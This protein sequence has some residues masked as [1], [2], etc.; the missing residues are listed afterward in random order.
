MSDWA[1]IDRQRKKLRD[2]RDEAMAKLLRLSKLEKALDEREQKM[3]ELGVSTL[4]ELDQK[5]AER[6]EFL[7]LEA[8]AANLNEA[9]VLMGDPFIDPEAL[10]NLPDSFWEGIAAS[11]SSVPVV[12]SSAPPGLSSG[13][14]ARDPGS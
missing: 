3:I 2:E 14:P 7:R 6:A 1:S 9:S 13:T 4:D 8:A 12:S 11:G 10:A 5:E